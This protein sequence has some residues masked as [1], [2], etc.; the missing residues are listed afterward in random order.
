M[1]EGQES[2]ELVCVCTRFR[3]TKCLFFGVNHIKV[4]EENSCT[5]STLFI[6]APCIDVMADL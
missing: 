3:L 4:K 5:Q 6:A 2:S 1:K